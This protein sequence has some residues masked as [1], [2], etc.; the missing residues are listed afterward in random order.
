MTVNHSNATNN[1]LSRFPSHEKDIYKLFMGGK[2]SIQTNLPVPT[3][4]TIANTA[5]ISLDAYINHVLGHGIPITFAH[6]SISSPNLT[7]LHR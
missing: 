7:G 3:T 4:F 1:I 5:C 6:D 2:H